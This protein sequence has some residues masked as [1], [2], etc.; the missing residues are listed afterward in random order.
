M[1]LAHVLREV[2]LSVICAVDPAL[3]NDN[4]SEMANINQTLLDNHFS[5]DACCCVVI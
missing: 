5:E 1:N 2:S 4:A 3:M